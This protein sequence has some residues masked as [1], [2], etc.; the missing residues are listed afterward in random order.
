MNFMLFLPE[1]LLAGLA[2]GVLG[3]DLFLPRERKIYLPWITLVGLVGV[4]VVSLTYM[5]GRD[6]DLYDGL[7]LIDNFSLFFKGFFLVLGALVVLVSVD[8]VKKHLSHPG[9]YYGILLFSILGMMLMTAAGELLTAYISLE[10]LSFSL[11][12]LVSYGRNNPKSNEAGIKYILLG[13]FASALLLY[14]ISQVYGMLGTTR[15][16]EIQAVLAFEP[17]PLNPALLVG[18]ALIVAGLGFKVAAVPFHMW[19]PDVYEGAPTP[20]TAYLAVGSKAAA[21]ALILRLFSQAFLPAID[22]WQIIL[23][24]LA[25]LTMTVGN[26]VALAQDNIKRML[27]YSS[28]GHVGYLLLGVAALSPLASDGVIFH[29]A[30]YGVTNLAA[31]L[32][33]IIFYNAT[34]REDIAGLAGLADRAPY[35]AMAFT[36]ALFSLAGLPFFAGF[37][38]KFYLFTAAAEGGLLWLVGLAIVN[39]LISLYYYLMVIKQMY[40]VPAG[41]N[42]PVKV[43]LLS[44]GVLGL[45]VLGI[46]VLGVYPGPLVDAI[47]GATAAILP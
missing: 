43:S 11:Y 12:V 14:G 6:T 28:I 25:A 35:L 39:S 1:F 24:V 31:F 41:E 3:I 40:M 16:S 2:F 20:I 44:G 10:L 42:A 4:L 22:D 21:F 8:Y 7:F 19:A 5:W 36:V 46:I 33:V 29:L 17:S 18:L 26:L 37:T 9:E 34:N 38:T 27:A 32:C 23:V 15:F 47:Q 13:A 30:G 45:L